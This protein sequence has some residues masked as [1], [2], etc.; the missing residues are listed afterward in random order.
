MTLDLSRAYDLAALDEPLAQGGY[1]LVLT[2]SNFVFGQ[3]WI[4]FIHAA[5]PE[6]AGETADAVPEKTPEPTAAPLAPGG[7]GRGA[8]RPRGGNAAA[9]FC[10]DRRRGAAPRPAARSTTPRAPSFSRR[11]GRA[12]RAP[13]R[14]ILSSAMRRMA[15]YL[16]APRRRTCSI[17][18]QVKTIR[19]ST[20]TAC[21][22]AARRRGSARPLRTCSA[23]RGGY[24]R[25][26]AHP[27]RVPVHVF[28]RGRRKRGLSLRPRPARA[29]FG[30][31][32]PARV[33]GRARYVCY[34]LSEFFYTDVQTHA[35]TLCA[36]RGDVCWNDAAR[37][38]VQNIYDYYT[39]TETLAM[40]VRHLAA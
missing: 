5:A 29:A 31:R 8:Y 15:S 10:N 11:W 33:R 36:Q 18:S 38:R 1:Y 3:D 32:R 19:R 21:R 2:N 25:R 14:R 6:T 16:I 4:C 23:A 27:G 20:P 37:Q 34:E 7:D 30:G 28:P 40:L 24:G 12:W 22:S 17:F 35:E 9:I 39:S 26:R 13:P